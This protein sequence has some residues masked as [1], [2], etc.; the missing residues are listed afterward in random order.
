LALIVTLEDDDMKTN[1]KR[2][3]FEDGGNHI[4][5][6]RESVLQSSILVQS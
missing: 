2:W 5:T 3:Y 6:A 1:K 4:T